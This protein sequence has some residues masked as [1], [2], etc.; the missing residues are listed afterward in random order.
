MRRIHLACKEFNFEEGT[1]VDPK[2]L[3]QRFCT[4]LDLGHSV[5]R[6]SCHVLDKLRAQTLLVGRQP[7]TVAAAAVL[8]SMQLPPEEERRYAS[9]LHR[10]SH[11]AGAT[12]IH[13]LRLMQARK[14]ELSLPLCE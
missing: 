10:V 8:F 14:H 3:V 6:E 11:M 12:I 1:P 2:Q 5:V 7:T 9:E 13:A 4:A